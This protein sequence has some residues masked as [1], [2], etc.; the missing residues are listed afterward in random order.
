MS[1]GG[2]WRTLAYSLLYPNNM[3]MSRRP[4]PWQSTGAAVTALVAVAVAFASELA[5]GF[6]LG[7][8]TGNLAEAGMAVA[9]VGAAAVIFSRLGPLRRVLA[10][11]LA[12]VLVS[13]FWALNAQFSTSLDVAY[14]GAYGWSGIRV[15]VLT[16][17]V[18]PILGLIAGILT[19]CLAA[20]S[21]QPPTT[22]N[23]DQ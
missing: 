12:F 20:L 9:L 10:A 18:G 1:A 8:T 5:V 11:L 16:V 13:A 22:S 3:V 2:G 23:P 15:A 21:R 14:G 7:E 19:F 17:V 4:C 6:R